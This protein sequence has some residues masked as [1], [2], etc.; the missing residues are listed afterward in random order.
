[1]EDRKGND[2]R[3]G[4]Q[5]RHHVLGSV[6]QTHLPQRVLDRDL[7]GE[8]FRRSEHP[9]PHLRVEEDSHSS[10]ALRMSSGSG[11]SKSSA[12]KTRPFSV[13]SGRSFT[14]GAAGTKRATGTPALAMIT[15]SPA[16]TRSR[17]LER[18]VLASWTLY[19]MDVI[20]A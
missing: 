1:M 6:G 10:N 15:S 11:A 8:P 12:T 20:L 19:F 9:Q 14:T 5:M 4:H 16:A 7:P 17:S 2:A 18:W 13:P 3:P